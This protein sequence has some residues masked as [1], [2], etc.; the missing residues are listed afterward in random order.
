MNIGKE[1]RIIH[2]PKPEPDE[3][4]RE[5]VEPAAPRPM[6]DPASPAREPAPIR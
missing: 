5:P 1:R 3:P 2:V 6:P 4:V